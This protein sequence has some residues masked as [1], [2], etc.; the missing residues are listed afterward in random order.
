MV[1][2]LWLLLPPRLGARSIPLLAE[3]PEEAWLGPTVHL[4]GIHQALR[5]LQMPLEVAAVFGAVYEFHR[6]NE[7]TVQQCLRLQTVF[8]IILQKTSGLTG[9]DVDRPPN[10]CA[11]AAA[12][13]W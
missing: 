11:P 8:R 10:A 5:I 9:V 6:S 3:W 4:Q 2:A 12:F 7:D 13:N 1:K